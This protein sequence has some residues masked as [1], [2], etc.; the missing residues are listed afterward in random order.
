MDK[1]MSPEALEMVAERFRLLSESIRLR[2]VNLLQDGAMSVSELTRELQTSQPN[3]SKHLKLLTDSGILRREQRGN[4]VYYSIAD[5]TIFDLCDVVCGS[6][7]ER[8]KEQAN[9]F[10][11]A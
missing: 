1:N 7:E 5:T 4:T 2:L 3:V 8:L 9:L 10:V 11:F 6:L